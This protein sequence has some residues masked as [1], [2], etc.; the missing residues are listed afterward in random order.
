MSGLMPMLVYYGVKLI[1]PR[2]VYATALILSA[3]FSS[4]TGTSWGSAATIGVVMMG[5]GNA[6]GANNAIIAGAI[7]GGAYF[8]DKMS[9]LSDTTNIAAIASKVNLYDHVASMLWTTG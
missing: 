8:G 3:L 2:F 4:F 5:V 6:I 7:V 1:N 9:P